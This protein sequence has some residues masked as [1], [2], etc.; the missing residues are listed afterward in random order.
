MA[1]AQMGAHDGLGFCALYMV[2]W[3]LVLGFTAL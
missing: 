3:L 2:G 1:A